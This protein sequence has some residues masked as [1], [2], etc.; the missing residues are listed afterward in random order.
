[1]VEFFTFI[2]IKILFKYIVRGRILR[3]T[4]SFVCTESKIEFDC[5]LP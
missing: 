3:S 1:V 2:I 4:V 5:K